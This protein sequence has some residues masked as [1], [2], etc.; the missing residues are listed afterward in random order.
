MKIVGNEALQQN[1]DETKEYVNNHSGHTIVDS[2]D[3]ALERKKNLKFEG[4][5]VENS[6]DSTIVHPQNK[7]CPTKAEWDAMTDA[8]K[9][10]PNTYWY[11]PWMSGD[12]FASDFTPI[13]TV[14]GVTGDYD[15]LHTA[16]TT[17]FPTSDYI[18]CD[19]S[20]QNIVDYPKLA[21]YFT[22]VYGSNNYFGGDGVTTFAAPDF[23]TDFPTNGMLCIKAQISSTVIT[24]AEVDDTSSAADKV[25]SSTKTKSVTDSIEEYIYHM[26]RRTRRNISSDLA[27]LPTAVAE[28]DLAKYG[29]AIGDYFTSPADRTLK[30]QSSN[31]STES[32]VTVRL[33]YHLADLNTYYGASNY[34][35][36]SVVSTPHIAIV[37]DTKVTRQW[38]T[39]DAS[40]VG[41]NGS[42]LQAFLQGESSGQVM[43]AIKADMIALFGGSTGYEHLISHQKLFTIKL[44]EWTWQAGKYIS[45]LTESEMYGHRE[46]SVN[47]HQEGEAVKPLELF[48][49]FRWNEIFGNIWIWLRN[50][51]AASDACHAS[52]RGHANHS[53]VS[54]TGR[55]AGLILF[56]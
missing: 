15:T 40:S 54:G 50:M 29:Y 41:Y 28:Q 18:I 38:H 19:G 20:V 44:A 23:T 49:K 47:S 1:I 42:T 43:A 13:G 4:N 27:N 17:I 24:Y 10:D 52:D 45:A 39:G 25:W 14:I 21:E 3:N 2:D 36:Y 31:S 46:W 55:A 22:E 53:S 35:S 33:V 34:S 11:L 56:H 12:M 30:Q 37:V 51:L 8:E 26:S 48:Q 6:E 9:N 32:N 16:G 7:V 5:N